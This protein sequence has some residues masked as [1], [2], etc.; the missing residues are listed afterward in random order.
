MQLEKDLCKGQTLFLIGGGPSLKTMD[1]EPLKQHQD[2]VIVANNAYKIFPKALVAHHADFVWW[3]WNALSF[4]ETFNGKYR[5]TTGAGGTKNCYSTEWC[6]LRKPKEEGLSKDVTAVHGM[7]AG[8]QILNIAYLLGAKR[9][10]LLGYDFNFGP[11]GETQW[12]TEHQRETN[13]SMWKEKMVPLFDST[14]HTLSEDGVTVYN[15][16]PNSELKCY[17]FIKDYTKFL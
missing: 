8:H 16:N 15:A 12:H 2:R 9:I 6:W 14:L 17:G 4:E 5:T 3:E 1:L 10:V 7:H 13:T 11:S